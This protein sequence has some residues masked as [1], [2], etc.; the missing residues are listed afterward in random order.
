MSFFDRTANISGST[1]KDFFEDVAEGLEKQDCANISG[2]TA[3]DFFEDVDEG[4]EKQDF[5]PSKEQ[6]RIKVR[7]IRLWKQKNFRQ[8]KLGDNIEMLLLDE[9]GGGFKQLL[10]LLCVLRMLL[11]KEDIPNY[12]FSFVEFDKILNQTQE[13]A[14]LVVVIERKEVTKNGSPLNMISFELDDLSGNKLRCTLW[15]NFAVEMCSVI[16]KSCNEA[17]IFVIQFAKMKSW[18]GVMGI[19]NT[20]F[21]T[22]IFINNYDIPEVL[23]FKERIPTGE[24]VH[25]EKLSTVGSG[26]LS[27]D[28][29]ILQ[30]KTIVEI[31]ESRE[32][33]TCLTLAEIIL[34]ESTQ[35]VTKDGQIL[36]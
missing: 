18:R 6:W 31:K 36:D 23:A 5:N 27:L 3:K 28:D 25:I 24:G 12:A 13:N 34:I 16:D 20:M 33:M 29:E 7:V 1:T 19:S 32:V 14:F 30:R 17:V 2:S 35:N 15:E 11:L 26:T 21:N 9:Q 22:K 10:G 4:L 8:S